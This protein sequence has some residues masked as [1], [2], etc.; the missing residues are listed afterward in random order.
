[1]VTGVRLEPLDGVGEGLMGWGLGEA[2]LADGFGGVEEHLLFGHAHTG[3]RGAR[4]MAGEVCAGL[5]EAGEAPRETVW[6][7]QGGG[8]QTG[9]LSED[10]ERLFHG[11]IPVGMPE[12]VTLADFAFLGGEYFVNAVGTP[13]ECTIEGHV[14]G[15]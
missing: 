14:L 1:M 10:L 3:E 11:P 5:A 12:D 8:G 15:N 6:H 2:E 13:A 4:G 7:L 9:E